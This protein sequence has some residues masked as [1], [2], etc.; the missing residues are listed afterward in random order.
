MTKICGF[1]FWPDAGRLVAG[2]HVNGWDD[3]DAMKELVISHA[4]VDVVKLA[5][6]SVPLSD[7]LA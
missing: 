2:M 7:V 4:V 6:P 3:A 5:D 1:A